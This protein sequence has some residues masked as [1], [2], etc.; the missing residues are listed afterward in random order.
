MKKKA[1]VLC[2]WDRLKEMGFTQM[3]AYTKLSLTD[4][5]KNLFGANIE[6]KR[7]FEHDYLVKEI[8]NKTVKVAIIDIWFTNVSVDD[9]TIF[10]G[11]RFEDQH[12]LDAIDEATKLK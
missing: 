9:E 4:K 12:V 1:K 2:L 6:P 8:N 7:L 11:R 3:D 10:D 5:V